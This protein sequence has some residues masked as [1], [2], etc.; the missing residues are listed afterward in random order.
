MSV[1]YI[2]IVAYYII[3]NHSFI[4]IVR[5]R[6]LFSHDD[7]TAVAVHDYYCR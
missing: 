5:T 1:I 3:L 7:D 2:M 6:E 4:I